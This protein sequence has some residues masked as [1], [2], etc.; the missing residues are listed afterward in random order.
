MSGQKRPAVIGRVDAESRGF[1]AP[2]RTHARNCM[3]VTNQLR[4]MVSL[5][6][7]VKSNGMRLWKSSYIRPYIVPRNN[8]AQ[9]CGLG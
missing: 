5:L 4:S 3:S 8:K 9:P 2:V 6:F 7:L 1:L